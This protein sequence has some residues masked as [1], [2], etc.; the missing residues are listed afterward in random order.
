MNYTPLAGANKTAIR[1]KDLH[2]DHNKNKLSLDT[3]TKTASPPR[4]HSDM[5]QRLKVL[6]MNVGMPSAPRDFYKAGNR[7][8]SIPVS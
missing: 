3:F 7:Q 1:G 8:L 2:A 4:K 6:S 5:L